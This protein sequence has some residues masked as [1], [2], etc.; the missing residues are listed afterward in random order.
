MA[1]SFDKMFSNACYLLVANFTRVPQRLAKHENI[2]QA[3]P[4]YIED[5]CTYT[6]VPTTFPNNQN[7][8]LN[9]LKKAHLTF[10][11]THKITGTSGP[12]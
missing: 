12:V 6:D 7:C 5:E 2:A 11:Q 10:E 4:V 3:W 1:N 9:L 8:L